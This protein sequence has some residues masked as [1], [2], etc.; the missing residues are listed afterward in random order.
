MQVTSLRQSDSSNKFG[1]LYIWGI[2]QS[3]DDLI[4]NILK[5]QDSDTLE[6]LRLVSEIYKDTFEDDR[7]YNFKP[8]FI[9]KY[10]DQLIKL[11]NE[12]NMF[13]IRICGFHLTNNQMM[14]LHRS[15]WNNIH[16][17]QCTININATTLSLIHE[18]MKII[19]ELAFCNIIIKSNCHSTIKWFLVDPKRP[20]KENLKYVQHWRYTI[21][22]L[23]EPEFFIK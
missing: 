19:Y 2:T 17:D 12:S 18:D 22:H 13:N 7:D 10:F 1:Y 9:D 20:D 11:I 15:N 4:K 23:G 14:R 21:S 5:A 16:Y 3:D 8:I 6:M